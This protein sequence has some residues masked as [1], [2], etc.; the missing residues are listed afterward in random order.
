MV[1]D[2][3]GV[4]D[5]NLVDAVLMNATRI[6]HGYAL[7]KHPLVLEKIKEKDI[8]IE[9][10]PISNQVVFTNLFSS[11]FSRATHLSSICKMIASSRFQAAIARWS[12]HHSLIHH[13]P[14]VNMTS[15]GEDVVLSS[16]VLQ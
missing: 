4:T 6:G 15:S 13:L 3:E 2:W 5:M 16:V 7:N 14:V 11:I 9:V 10:N 1:P 8:G 12:V